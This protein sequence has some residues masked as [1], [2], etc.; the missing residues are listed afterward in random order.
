MDEDRCGTSHHIV[1]VDVSDGEVVVARW[2]HRRMAVIWIQVPAEVWSH[3]PG[4]RLV[5]SD[6]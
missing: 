5:A 6:H 3:W 4:S 1:G 2:V